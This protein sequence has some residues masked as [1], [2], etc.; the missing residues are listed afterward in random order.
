MGG[1]ESQNVFALIEFTCSVMGENSSSGTFFSVFAGIFGLKNRQ[2][3]EPKQKIKTNAWVFLNLLTLS[4][5]FIVV[6]AL[7]NTFQ[8]YQ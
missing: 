6:C 5:V 4:Q 1:K 8:D 3:K 7:H 2:N